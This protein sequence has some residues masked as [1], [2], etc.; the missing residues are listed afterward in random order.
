M[1][2]MRKM[3]LICVVYIVL[4]AALV[5]VCAIIKQG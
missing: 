2:L 4:V 1:V 5:H 3:V